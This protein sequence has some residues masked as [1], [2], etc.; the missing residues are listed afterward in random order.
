MSGNREE[1]RNR[2]S[3]REVEPQG[4]TCSWCLVEEP[5]AGLVG[6]EL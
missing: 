3:R 5:G 2:L 6:G 4:E 1:N